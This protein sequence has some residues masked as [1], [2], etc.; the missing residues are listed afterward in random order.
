MTFDDGLEDNYTIAY[1]IL[2]EFGLKAYFFLLV[3]RIGTTGYM[4]WEQV[5]RLKEGGMT[6]GSHGMT[7][8]I[9]TELSDNELD[10]ELFTSK[11]KIEAKLKSPVEYFSL[12]RGF[13][14]RKI[15]EKAKHAGY[16]KIFTSSC[17]DNNS[18]LVGRIPVK[19]SWEIDY[20]CKVLNNGLSLRDKTERFVL[21]SSK[22]I[23]GAKTYDRLRTFIL[24]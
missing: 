21:N 17:E 23:L 9:L 10:Y 22:K 6:I 15:I 7:H 20:F 11:S 3:G 5:R 24:K 4:N 18:F 13:S 12:P 8:R 19:G 1:P 14:N 16:K 2:K